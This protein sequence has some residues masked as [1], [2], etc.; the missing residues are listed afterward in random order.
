MALM[1]LGVFLSLLIVGANL[2]RTDWSAPST[3]G[4]SSR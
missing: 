2:L 1:A 4:S 3:E